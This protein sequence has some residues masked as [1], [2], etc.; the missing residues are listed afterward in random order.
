[1][2][3]KAKPEFLIELDSLIATKSKD[4]IE[5]HEKWFQEYSKLNDAKKFAIKIWRE[6]KKVIKF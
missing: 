6:N 1:M 5:K 4:E 3:L 2:Y